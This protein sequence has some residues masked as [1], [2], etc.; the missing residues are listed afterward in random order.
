M[1]LPDRKESA[2]ISPSAF[3]ALVRGNPVNAALLERLPSLA[4]PQ[5]HLVAGCLYQTVW[6]HRSGF[7]PTAM[8]KDYDVFYFDESDLSWE[9]EDDVIRR[10]HALCADLGAVVEV[11]NQARV[12][13][14]YERRFGTPYPKLA[15]ATGGIDRYLICGTRVGIDVATGSLYA[16]DGPEDSWRGI[17]RMNPV[18]P[19]PHLFLEK[20]EDLKRRWNWL[21]IVRQ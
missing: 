10:V 6:N 2:A 12:H 16:P 5:C 17:L 14:W 15:S 3:T 19:I 8:I 20:A 11:K 21:T 9:A 1:P 4:L 7:S 13:L 18:N